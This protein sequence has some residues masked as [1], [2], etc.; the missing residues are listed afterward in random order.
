MT[1]SRPRVH[2]SLLAL[3]RDQALPSKQRQSGEVTSTVVVLRS[4]L[5]EALGY[6]PHGE[7]RRLA[8]K[9][10]RRVV[11]LSNVAAGTEVPLRG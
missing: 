6:F 11:K 1:V 4:Q 3:S 10:L 2:T 5:L 7:F 8:I 9:R